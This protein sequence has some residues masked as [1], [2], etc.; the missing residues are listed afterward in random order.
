MRPRVHR[1]LVDQIRYLAAE[2][3]E[4]PDHP[5]LSEDYQFARTIM[6]EQI[7]LAMKHS[8][9]ADVFTG[10]AMNSQFD[11]KICRKNAAESWWGWRRAIRKARLYHSFARILLELDQEIER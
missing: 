10:R 3:Y 11:I 5:I 6:I 1:H 7:S 9:Q 2:L 8:M 4:L